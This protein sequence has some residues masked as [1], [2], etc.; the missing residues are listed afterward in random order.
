MTLDADAATRR[1]ARASFDQLCGDAL[2]AADY[3][4]LCDAYD[5]FFL[6]RVPVL[7]L[8]RHAAS[9]VDVESASRPRRRRDP[10]RSSR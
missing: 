1:C 7:P 5:C 2:G 4:A 8:A 10:L 6:E 3:H 9:G